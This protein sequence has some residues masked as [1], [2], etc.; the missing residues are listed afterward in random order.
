[1]LV[2]VAMFVKICGMSS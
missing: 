2:N 1:M